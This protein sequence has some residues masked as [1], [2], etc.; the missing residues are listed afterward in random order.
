MEAPPILVCFAVKEEAKVFQQILKMRPRARVVLTG[1]GEKNA[2]AAILAALQTAH[3]SLVISSGF[4]G[5]LNPALESGTI[6]FDG[7]DPAMESELLASGGCGVKFHHADRVATTAAEK[8]KLHASTG[9]D[10]VEMESRAIGAICERAG[11]PF[12]TVRVVLDT[13]NED[14][15]VD[16]NDLMTVGQKVSYLKLAGA[17]MKS[18]GKI[19]GLKQLQRQSEAAALKLAHALVKIIPS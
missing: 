14:L 10:A 16:F 4:A 7:V 12:A 13:A 17:V 2:E 9:A 6:V 3:P 18:P 11:I 5:G 19:S 1:I 15:P 8:Q